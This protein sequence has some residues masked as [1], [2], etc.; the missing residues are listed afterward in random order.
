MNDFPLL[1][2]SLFES[3][4][5]TS[6]QA[7]LVVVAILTTSWLFRNRLSCRVRHGLWL[8]L[9]FK[10]VIP[11]APASPLSL[12]NWMPEKATSPVMIAQEK[13][14]IVT[15]ERFIASPSEDG[16]SPA[17]PLDSILN[18][19]DDLASESNA[20]QQPV[21][22]APPPFR[23]KTW[24]SVVWL[25]GCFFFLIQMLPRSVRKSFPGHPTFAP[26]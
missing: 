1:L 7:S 11:F 22:Y 4:L 12:F 9:L 18:R 3:T 16:G 5:T 6:W 17:M 21:S 25:V 19:S 2:K 24:L 23:W 10:L 13:P 8:I 14:V 20:A 15:E 26:H